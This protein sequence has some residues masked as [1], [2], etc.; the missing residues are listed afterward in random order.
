MIITKTYMYKGQRRD[1]F[2]V[3]NCFNRIRQ[4]VLRQYWT[5]HSLTIVFI[6]KDSGEKL[7]SFMVKNQQ[8]MFI[9]P[10]HLKEDFRRHLSYTQRGMCPPLPFTV[11]QQM[12]ITEYRN[13][14]TST[15]SF[16]LNKLM[17]FIIDN[18]QMNLKEKEEWLKLFQK[19]H[20]DIFLQQFPT[21][22]LWIM[23]LNYVIFIYEELTSHLM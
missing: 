13:Q 8:Q 7:V 3:D 15:T 23:T 2:K 1:L 14:T 17:T 22:Q 18:L 16:S 20:N 5:G 21:G 19:H 4:W 6:S 12:T 11:C 10:T 9:M